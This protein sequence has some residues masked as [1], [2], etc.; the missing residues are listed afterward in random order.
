A[1]KALPQMS[2]PHPQAEPSRRPAPEAISEANAAAPPAAPV[3]IDPERRN[4]PQPTF[5][6]IGGGSLAG[7]APPRRNTSTSVRLLDSDPNME[8]LAHRYGEY[9]AKL[10][11]QLQNSLNR[12]MVLSPTGYTAGQVKIRFGIT[13]DGLLDFQETLFPTDG[14]LTAERMMSER[15]LR[16]AGPFDP[17]TPGM[18]KDVELF[19]RLT[20]VIHLYM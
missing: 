10:A 3:Q 18:M 11:R 15:M 19:Q 12:E 8:L 5:R 16:E 6:S 20:V 9:M 4:R 13:P 2:P 7:G 17:F 14:S 1:G